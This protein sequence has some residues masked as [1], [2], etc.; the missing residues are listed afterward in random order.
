MRRPFLNPSVSS[1][2]QSRN[3][4]RYRDSLLLVSDRGSGIHHQ[5]QQ[6]SGH[7]FEP[8]YLHQIGQ[9]LSTD[10]GFV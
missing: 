6:H 2:H 10:L 9:D 3:G 8:V 1:S 5:A 7:K 4:A